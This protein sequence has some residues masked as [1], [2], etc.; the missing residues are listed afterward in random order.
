MKHN[1]FTHT[2][3]VSACWNFPI[4]KCIFTGDKC[5]FQHSENVG[6]EVQCKFCEK[7]F[8]N[9][10]EYLNPRKKYDHNVVPVCRNNSSG[11]CVYTNETCW[12]NHAKKNEDIKN[13]EN[14]KKNNENE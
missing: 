9:H 11:S 5:W 13:N 2:D 12:F 10:S 1:T 8:S 3:K 6:E 7:C 4:G 14:Q